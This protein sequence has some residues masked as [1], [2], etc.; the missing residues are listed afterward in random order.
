MAANSRN[1]SRTKAMSQRKKFIQ[2]AREHG[3]SE[4]ELRLMRT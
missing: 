3:A 4:D 2:A 1:E